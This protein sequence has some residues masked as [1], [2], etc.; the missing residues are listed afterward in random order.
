MAF[1]TFYVKMLAITNKSS[2]KSTHLDIIYVVDA[3]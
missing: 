2:Y 3:L 1:R